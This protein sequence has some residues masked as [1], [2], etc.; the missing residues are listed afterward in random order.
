MGLGLAG[1]SGLGAEYRGRA[2]AGSI[3]N[4]YSSEYLVLGLNAGAGFELTE[5]LSAGATMTVGTGFEQMGFVTNGA[6]VHDYGIRGTFGVDYELN[7]R[8]T[9]GAFYTTNLGFE[10]PNAFRLPNGSY[11]DINMEQ[12]QTL[13]LGFANRALMDGNLLVAADI[14][15][16]LWEDA[17]LYEDIFVNQWAFAFGTQ[18]TRGRMKYRAGYSYNTNPINH[19][20]GDRLSG[21]PVLQDQIFFFQAAETAAINQH[22]LTGGIGRSDFLFPGVD[23]DL[24]VGGLFK[25]DDQFGPNTR[26]SVAMYYLGLGLTWRFGA[27]A[28]PYDE[29]VGQAAE[30]Q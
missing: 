17:D 30:N 21:L 3:A 25:A 6:M 2:P 16:K 27:P 15:Y 14:Y 23:L 26:A 28:D 19:N 10:F 4:D 18:L 1:L 24:F 22:R 9:V 5:K 29:C 11:T 20:V 12:P 13:G 8:N 7:S